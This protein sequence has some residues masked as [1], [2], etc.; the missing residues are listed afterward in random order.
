MSEE[1]LVNV[2]P[3]ETR[4]AVVQNGGLQELHIERS[5]GRGIVANIYKGKVVKVL[6]GM[7]AAFV[8]IGLER[9]AFIHVSDLSA[10]TEPGDT[11]VDSD[12]DDK[13]PELPRPRRQTIRPIEQLL[14]EGNEPVLFDHD[15]REGI[16]GMCSLTINGVPHGLENATTTCQLHMRHFKDGETIWIE[17]FRANAFPIVKDLVVELRAAGHPL[18]TA[19]PWSLGSP[20]RYSPKNVRKMARNMYSAV[21]N[22]V[23]T[24]M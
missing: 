20:P 7:Q 2:T 6:P 16:C 17:P 13:G 22:A 23:A 8:D 21:R 4:V 14:E 3:Q 24:P 1:L 15:C 9:A 11:L 5:R 18:G 10:E 19:A 12:E